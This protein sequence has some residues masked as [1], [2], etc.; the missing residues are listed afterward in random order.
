MK[1]LL[2]RIMTVAMATIITI[3]TSITSYGEENR[4]QMYEQIR[5]NID[6]IPLSETFIRDKINYYLT[7]PVFLESYNN[8]FD[9]AI[10]VVNNALRIEYRTQNSVGN[11][12][13]IV[14]NNGT[15]FY[16][17][18]DSSIVQEQ[19]TWCGVGSTLM[20]LTGIENNDSSDLVSGYTRPTQPT[21]ATN[22]VTPDS[23]NTAVVAQIVS[24]LNKKIKNDKYA[25]VKIS[26]STT[27]SQICNYIKRS[28][29]ANRPVILRSYPY[30]TISYYNSL[31]NADM[32]LRTTAH[33]IVVEGYDSTT[34]TFTVSDCTDVESNNNNQYQGR[35]YNVSMTEIY[36]CLQ[37]PYD[38]TH[39][40]Y[41]IYA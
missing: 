21:I 3:S 19:D 37:K 6:E 10:E 36:N 17:H 35:H 23:G 14:A 34:N 22:V 20:V 4:S 24:Y 15:L 1:K 32:D 8:D 2:K 16:C 7:D 28:L 5:S 39:N 40:G 11:N 18:V 26:S 29:G 9:S 13:R 12:S 41:I 25:Y 31:Y 33:Y 30:G 27:N 38:A